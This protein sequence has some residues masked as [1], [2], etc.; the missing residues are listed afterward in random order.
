MGHSARSPAGGATAATGVLGILAITFTAWTEGVTLTQPDIAQE[1]A[2]C[3][4]GRFDPL[5]YPDVTG[6]IQLV[7]AVGNEAINGPGSGLD[8]LVDRLPLALERVVC[9][10]ILL[11]RRLVSAVGRG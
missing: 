5:P 3:R 6:L 2:K 7:Q 1:G 9:L 8:Q 10:V 11:V 4:S